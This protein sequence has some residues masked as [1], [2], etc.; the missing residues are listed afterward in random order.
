MRRDVFGAGHESFRA[1]VAGFVTAEVVPHLA[2]WAQDGAVSRSFY[3]RAGE[4]GLL[5]LGLDAA[6]GGRGPRDFRYNAVV[7]EEL[8]RVGAA[9]LVINLGGLNDLVAPYLDA[10]CTEEQ[11]RRWLPG[12]CSGRLVSALAMTERV[13]GSDLRGIRTTAVPDGDDYVLTGSKVF[14]GNG[15]NADLVV[16]AAKLGS[17]ERRDALTLFVVS[18][19]APGLRRTRLD[20]IGLPAQDTAELFFDGV[21]VPRADLL[22]AEDQGFGYLTQNLPQERL[23]VAITAVAGMQH[24]FGHTRE[25]V[26]HREAFGRPL[27]ALQTVRFT[28]AELAT[29]IEVAQVFV[30]KALHELVAGT[31]TDVDAA[32]VKW[33]VTELQQQVVS[34]CLQLYGG[35]GYLRDN[36]AARDLLDSRHSTLYAGTTE[37][38]KEIIGRSVTGAVRRD[39]PDG[40]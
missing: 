30:D 17:P 13:A 28:L 22:G 31:L 12:L 24:T 35:H 9:S 33:W 16:V 21:R 25:H 8:C 1:E 19:D 36:P 11:K 38:M 39:E 3:R 14:I 23:S 34:R 5:G 29:E 15:M 27:A 18:G 7:I 10:L 4:A 2:Q 26:L 40:A 20:K 37:I 6:H 32:M